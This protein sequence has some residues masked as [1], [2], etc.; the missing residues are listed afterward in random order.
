[1]ESFRYPL[2][3]LFGLAAAALL[4][5]YCALDSYGTQT[6]QSRAHADPAQLAMAEKRLEPLKRE[7]PPGTLV[8]YVSD[9]QA[10]SGI[11]L[12]T[13][14]ALAPVMLTQEA[15]PEF[16]LGN[17]SRPLNYAEFGTARHLTLVKDFGY[18]VVLFRK[19]KP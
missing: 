18:G 5:L 13:Q 8:G 11:I 1:M 15:A 9:I 17:F 16:V 19:A 3:T 10:D 12:V 2:R 7:L 4:S 14:Y 6:L